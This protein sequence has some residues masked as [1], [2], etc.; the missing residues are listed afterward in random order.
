MKEFT[1]P[2]TGGIAQIDILNENDMAEVLALHERTRAALPTD[3]KNFIL[4]QDRSYFE[5]LL[6]GTKGAM[7]GIRANDLLVAQLALVGPLPLREAISTQLITHNDVMFH[8]AALNDSVVVFKSM[9]S[10]PDWRGNDLAKNITLFAGDIPLTR[11]CDHIFMQISVGNRRS[12][13]VFARQNYGI[14]AAAYDPADGLPRF[15]F[16]KPAFGFDFEPQ[17]MAD[18]V[19]PAADFPAII[20]LTQ[21]EGLVGMYDGDSSDKLVFLRNREQE[22]SLMPTV[23]RVSA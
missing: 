4:P 6:S 22:L 5:G 15:I 21:R 10:H 17:V 23:A 20:S 19:D 1:L 11:A 9:A 14:V 3:K 18:D 13:E 7:V 2:K 12:W 8:H 16:Q